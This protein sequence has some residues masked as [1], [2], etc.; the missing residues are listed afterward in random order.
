V[1]W[2][3]IEAGKIRPAVDKTFPLAQAAEAHAHLEGG[4]HVGKVVL[5]AEGSR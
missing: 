2:P 3:W 5:D 1:V 4:A